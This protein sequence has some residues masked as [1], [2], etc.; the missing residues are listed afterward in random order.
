VSAEVVVPEDDGRWTPAF[1]TQREPFKPGHVL[2]LRHGVFSERA[3]TPVAQRVAE[4]VLSIAPAMAAYPLE[5][6]L[7]SRTYGVVLLIDAE[8]DRIGVLDERGGPRES[9]LKWRSS[10]ARQAMSQLREMGLTRKAAAEL[11]L[12]VAAAAQATVTAAQRAAAAPAEVKAF[13]A[14]RGVPAADDQ[15]PE[16]V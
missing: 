7:Y 1:A 10:F 8:L 6:D 14:G 16:D 3:I 4:L 13:L 11:Q 5:V 15:D 9:L 2:S 12:D